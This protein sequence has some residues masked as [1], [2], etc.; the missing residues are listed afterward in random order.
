MAGALDFLRQSALVFGAC[1]G[2]AAR[3]NLTLFGDET[4]QQ[5]GIFVIDVCGFFYTELANLWA[6]YV[7]P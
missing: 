7:S 1:T 4:A 3:S 6:R 2:L 5:F